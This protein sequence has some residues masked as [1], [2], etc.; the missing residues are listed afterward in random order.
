MRVHPRRRAADHCGTKQYVRRTN[1]GERRL[2]EVPGGV[3]K[4]VVPVLCIALL[5]LLL[6]TGAYYEPGYLV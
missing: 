3:E 5:L 6:S 4:D 2:A 1:E